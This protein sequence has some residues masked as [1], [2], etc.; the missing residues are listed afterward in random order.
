MRLTKSTDLALRA[1][2]ALAVKDEPSTARDVAEAMR[3]PYSHL[4]K[5][6]ARLQIG[7]AHV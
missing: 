2:M 6:V 5:V 3:V 4:A 7:R 1:V